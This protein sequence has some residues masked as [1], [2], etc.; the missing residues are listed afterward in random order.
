MAAVSVGS[1]SKTATLTAATADTVTF[2]ASG[3]IP[4]E[5]VNLDSSA[6]IWFRVDGT[7]SVAGTDCIP[8]PPLN[9]FTIPGATSIS[10]ISA[11]TPQY[12]VSRLV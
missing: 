10:V 6:T 11:G 8:L 4:C 5:I 3:P 7:A 12:T 9:A 1:V 2:T